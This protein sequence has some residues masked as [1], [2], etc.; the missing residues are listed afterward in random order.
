MLIKW[1]TKAA[2]SMFPIIGEAAHNARD[3]RVTRIAST[4]LTRLTDKLHNRGFVKHGKRFTLTPSRRSMLERRAA[5]A[6]R[7]ISNLTIQQR[8]RSTLAVCSSVAS[9]VTMIVPQL[10]CISASAKKCADILLQEAK[11]DAPPTSLRDLVIESAIAGGLHVCSR[12]IG[13]AVEGLTD[14][15][16]GIGATTASTVLHAAKQ[17]FLKLFSS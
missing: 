12:H 15:P 4:Y 9:G 11:S 17:L 6:S 3:A 8:T 2:S 14:I 13:Q 7:C 10:G 1:I 5:D 16:S